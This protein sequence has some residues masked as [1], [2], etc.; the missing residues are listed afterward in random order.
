MHAEGP[1]P[2]VGVKFS[3][4]D[5]FLYSGWAVITMT[6]VIIILIMAVIIE[7]VGLVFLD[8]GIKEINGAPR[9]TVREI[10]RVIVAGATN[11]KMLVGTALMAVF[12]GA[13][14]YL[15]SLRD[16]SFVW[17]MTSVGFI[18]TALTAEFVLHENVSWWRWGGILLITLGAALTTYGEKIKEQ[19]ASPVATTKM[20]M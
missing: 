19:P 8:E 4:L 5:N 15:L 20:T 10:P 16:V 1:S 6:R 11:R 3:E 12:F 13:L 2:A 14:L 18:F 7:S 17:P 9:I